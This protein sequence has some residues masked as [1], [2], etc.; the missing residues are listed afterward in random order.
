M[1]IL[2]QKLK[3]PDETLEALFLE[4]SDIQKVRQ[5]I[6]A[7]QIKISSL[8]KEK[9]SLCT[10]AKRLEREFLRQILAYQFSVPKS[11]IVE[12]EAKFS[13]SNYKLALCGSQVKDWDGFVRRIDE[14]TE[15]WKH[16]GC[17]IPW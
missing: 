15:H 8:Q 6:E 2:V 12:Q 7:V 11:A 3:S 14:H 17:N 4:N 10:K 1:D 9:K 16:I 13:I 5:E